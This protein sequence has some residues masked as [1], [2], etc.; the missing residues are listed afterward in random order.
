[1]SLLVRYKSGVTMSYHLVSLVAM[2]LYSVHD[3]IL[4]Y[5]LSLGRI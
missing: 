2:Y 3:I 4:D 5:V 1:M